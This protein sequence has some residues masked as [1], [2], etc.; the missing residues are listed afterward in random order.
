MTQTKRKKVKAKDGIPK[1]SSMPSEKDFSPRRTEKFKPRN[2][3][4]KKVYEDIKNHTV[5][6]V[7]GAVGT[8]K[9]FVAVKTATELLQS[10]DYSKLVIIRANVSTEEIGFL[11]GTLE[12]KIS[13]YLESMTRPL[14]EILGNVTFDKMVEIGTIVKE[15]LGF[16]RGLS[17]K[18][19]IVLVDEIQNLTSGQ[20]RLLLT[21]IED[22]CKMI[23][24]GDMRQ[25]DLE[26]PELTACNDIKKFKDKEEISINIFNKSEIVRGKICRIIDSC[27]NDDIYDHVKEDAELYF[28]D[29][30]EKKS[31]K[32]SDEIIPVYSSNKY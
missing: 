8:G 22:N 25:I 24:M 5:N 28:P 6:F 26:I 16:T 7:L 11:K 3:K 13:P 9:T 29:D 20:M 1:L 14:K 23:L 19:C 4:Q 2:E 32:K 18:N 17:Y 30:F 21:R 27:Y 15:G 10:K 12:E 31:R